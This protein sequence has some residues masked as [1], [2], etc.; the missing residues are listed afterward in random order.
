MLYTGMKT[1]LFDYTNFGV[2]CATVGQDPK[3]R[4]EFSMLRSCILDTNVGRV[5]PGSPLYNDFSNESCQQTFYVVDRGDSGVA[6]GNPNEVNTYFTAKQNKAQ[7]IL[8][9]VRSLTNALYKRSFNTIN[10][11]GLPMDD[12]L[13]WEVNQSQPNNNYF[14]PGVI[15]YANTLGITAAEAYKELALEYQTIHGIK[16]RTYAVAKKYQSLIREINTLPQA[17]DLAAEIDQ[18]LIKETFI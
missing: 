13:A 10:E 4:W 7:L 1:F 3:I 5:F 12:T 15:E 16:M 18:K 8:P 6:L 2:L 14:S 11:F 17:Q 9:L